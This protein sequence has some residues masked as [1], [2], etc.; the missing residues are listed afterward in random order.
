MDVS[1]LFK[2]AGAGILIAITSQILQRAGRE[3]QAS[4]LSLAGVIVVLLLLVGKIG[5]LFTEVRTIFGL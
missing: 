3:E 2:I 5:D 4:L 1:L